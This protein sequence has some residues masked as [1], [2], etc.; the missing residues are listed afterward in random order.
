MAEWLNMV[1]W[2]WCQKVVRV[3]F[4]VTQALCLRI[5]KEGWKYE[6]DSSRYLRVEGVGDRGK[7]FFGVI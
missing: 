3:G 1:S 4:K 6:E 7:E 5:A 2:W